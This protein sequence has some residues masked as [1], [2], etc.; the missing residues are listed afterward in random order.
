MAAAMPAGM[1]HFTI[2][3]FPM[4]VALYV[5]TFV[6][7]YEGAGRPRRIGPVVWQGIWIGV[8]AAPL[9]LATSPWA[10]RAFAWTNQD[11]GLAHLETT[12]YQVLTFGSG[13]MIIAAAQTSFFIGRGKTRVVMFVDTGGHLVERRAGLRLDLRAFRIPGRRHRRRRLGHDDGRV[14][15]RCSCTAGSCCGPPSGRLINWRPAGGPM[16]ESWDGYG[17]TA[18]RA[19][20]RPSSKSP[21]SRSFSC[22]WG[23][24][25]RFPWPRR[26]WPSPSI[27]WP[28]CRC[29]VWAPRS[30][31]W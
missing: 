22:S 29:G 16:R 23:V 27:T 18:G 30:R 6:A 3:S 14:G 20:C 7:Q 4:G 25:E 9:L 2:I 8:F 26:P 1:F 19:D 12:F 15:S 21:P 10:P 31:Q 5:N 17:A 13:A 24:W 28:G 11:P